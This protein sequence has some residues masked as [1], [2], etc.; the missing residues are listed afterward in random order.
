M[1]SSDSCNPFLIIGDGTCNTRHMCS[2]QMSGHCT[3]I[4]FYWIDRTR[5]IPT[6]P[7]INETILV[8][9]NAI[10]R[11]IIANGINTRFPLIDIN[12]RCQ[13][14]MKRINACIYNCDQ[15]RIFFGLTHVISP[16]RISTNHRRI[17]LISIQWI[18][19]HF[20]ECM[21]CFLLSIFHK[22]QSTNRGEYF[23]Q[24]KVIFIFN[25]RNTLKRMLII[26][27][28]F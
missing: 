6:L 3:I 18:I 16:S 24:R 26:Q 1:M 7:I 27:H 17:I 19:W 25:D 5:K 20:Y 28:N 9:I 21:L 23:L 13:I 15:H 11:F 14:F 4:S 22:W 8:I 2:M 10:C 12:D